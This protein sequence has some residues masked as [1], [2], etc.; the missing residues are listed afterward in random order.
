MSTT[1]HRFATRCA[2]AGAKRSGGGKNE[3]AQPPIVQSAIFD[4]GGTD[5]A[6]AIL[7]G[8]RKGNAY[9]RLASPTVGALAR[10]LAALESGAEAL[11][12][13]SRPSVEPI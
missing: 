13:R 9:S 1:P 3:P 2:H 4:L 11:V 7:S 8:T 6:A 10:V 12:T 5:D